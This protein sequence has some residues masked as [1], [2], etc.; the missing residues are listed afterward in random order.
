MPDR[1]IVP[2]RSPSPNAEGEAGRQQ[3]LYEWAIRVL[4]ERGLV[5]QIERAASLEQLRKVAFDPDAIEVALAIRA[6]LHP[7][8]GRK[9]DCFEG[10]RAGALKRLLNNRFE[11]MKNDREAELL[12]GHPAGGAQSTYEWTDELKLDKKGAVRPLLHN[13]ILFLRYH[14]QWQDVLGFD[15]F[16]ARVVVRKRPPWGDEAPDAPWTDHYETL[17][18]KWFQGE[19]INAAQGDVGRAVQAAARAN[20]FHPVR[21][22]FEALV[23]DRTPRLDMWLVTYFDAHNSPYV[24]A[25]GPRFLISAVARINKPGEKVDHMPVLEGPQGKQKSEALRTLAIQDRWFTDRLSHIGGKDAIM[26][27]AGALLIEIAEMD[28][29]VRASSSASKGFHAAS[30]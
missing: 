12:R 3:R 23:W 24:R 21:D 29:L 20:T 5:E 9:D 13:L 6:A 8:S 16:T 18:R 26:E 28:A 11:D 19:D 17:T 27:T 22:Y 14:R 25:V 4:T 10:L 2:F 7:T 30:R 15:E 1:T